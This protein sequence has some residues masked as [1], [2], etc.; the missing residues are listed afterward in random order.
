MRPGNNARRPRGRPNRKQHGAPRAHSYDS[1]G[2]DVRI[3]GNAP[4]VYDK[5]ITLARDATVSGDRVAAESYY[6]FAEHYFRIMND[7][8]DPRRTAQQPPRSG[9]EQPI[10]DQEQPQVDWPVQSDGA[11]GD[12]GKA[13]E[14]TEEKAAEEPAPPDE[15]EAPRRAA[16]GRPRGRRRTANGAKD[17]S[18][19]PAAEVKGSTEG[20][21]ADSSD[22]VSESAEPIQGP[23][24]SEN[25]TP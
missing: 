8:T 17:P 22:G 2:H 14:Q 12:A 20:A 16:R 19:K 3:R 15:E 21:T 5:Y 6:Q 4:Q 24:D 18:E 9:Q 23:D 11:N 1:H 10:L 7:S 13:P 25:A